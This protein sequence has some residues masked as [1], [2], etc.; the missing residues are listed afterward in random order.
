MTLGAL[1][2]PMTVDRRADT[3]LVRLGGVGGT[4]SDV[5]ERQLAQLVASHPRRVLLDLSELDQ[6]SGVLL[7][8]L[9]TLRRG[10]VSY[11]GE[12]RIVAAQ[13]IVLELFRR[14]GLNIVFDTQPSGLAAS[15][16][17]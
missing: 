9:L 4:T 2:F 12:I 15:L 1:Q 10:V 8:V 13:P 7:G 11:G 17:A 6:V 14:T 5:L 3:T 16:P